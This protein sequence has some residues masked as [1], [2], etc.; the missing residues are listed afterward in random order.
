M[1]RQTIT[2]WSFD[3]EIPHGIFVREA[4][5]TQAIHGPYHQHRQVLLQILLQ[6][7]IKTC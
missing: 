5:S 3:A 4:H 1:F 7:T 6:I 2:Q